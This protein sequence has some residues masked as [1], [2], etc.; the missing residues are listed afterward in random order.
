MTGTISLQ[1]RPF[2]MRTKVPQDREAADAAVAAFVEAR[3]AGR[4]IT[5]C[6]AEAVERWRDY[7]PEDS[8]DDA[9]KRVISII[10]A[11]RHA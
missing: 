2:A 9:A 11:V 7:F 6:Y 5:D 1:R 10:H 3:A 8:A 4:S